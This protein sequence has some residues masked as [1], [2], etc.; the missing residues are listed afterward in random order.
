MANT[1]IGIVI[2]M[3]GIFIGAQLYKGYKNKVPEKEPLSEN[4]FLR[5]CHNA[6]NLKK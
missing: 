5:A 3:M 1:L 2:F 6:I 4:E